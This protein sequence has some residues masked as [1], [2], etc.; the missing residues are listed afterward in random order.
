VEAQECKQDRVISSTDYDNAAWC[1]NT[2][3][4]L[5]LSLLTSNQICDRVGS[6]LGSFAKLRKA[7]ISFVMSVSPSA[8]NI[9]APTGRKSM[10]FDI[11]LS[12]ICWENSRLIKILPKK[13]GTLHEYQ[14]KFMKISGQILLRMRNVS[15]KILLR[16]SKHTFYIQ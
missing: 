12:K 14:R 8:W 9:S 7:T 2:G 3:T 5:W 11:C 13:N 1:L 15:E 16:K 10:E 6:I 4:N